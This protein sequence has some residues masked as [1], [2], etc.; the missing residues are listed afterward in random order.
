[1][2]L[3]FHMAR[4]AMLIELGY[5]IVDRTEGKQRRA[6]IDL[7]VA[8]CDPDSN[9]KVA[10]DF[11]DAI[12]RVRE[13]LGPAGL[14]VCE[15]L[16]SAVK[17]R[18]VPIAGWMYGAVTTANRYALLAAGD[19]RAAIQAL[20]RTDPRSYGEKF[21]TKDARLRALKRS[22]ALTDLLR[23]TLSE[24]FERLR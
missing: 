21:D 20:R 13:K 5:A 1:A 8:A 14:A 16:A 9:I 3:R 12:D 23:F 2:E 18:E 7:I 4:A 19:L 11:G 17:S 22:S 24:S 10:A 6:M 15:P